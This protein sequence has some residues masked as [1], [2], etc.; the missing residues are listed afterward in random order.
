MGFRLFLLLKCITDN[1]AD[2][3]RVCE[4]V[5]FSVYKYRKFLGGHSRTTYQVMSDFDYCSL[6][7]TYEG[8]LL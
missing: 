4:T 5:G 8:T 6:A 7:N 1:L 3:C 2:R